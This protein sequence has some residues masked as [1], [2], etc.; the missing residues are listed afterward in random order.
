[1]VDF[2]FGTVIVA[3]ENMK[4]K[5]S[6]KDLLLVAGIVV[7]IIIALTTWVFTENLPEASKSMPPSKKSSLNIAPSTM[8][9][10]IVEKTDLG[11]TVQ[12]FSR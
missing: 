8:I 10:R 2:S 1:M 6:Y 5:F 11:T 12:K 4:M 3:F 7:A 9:K